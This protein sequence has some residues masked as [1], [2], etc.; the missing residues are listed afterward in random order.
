MFKNNKS[1]TFQS[2]LYTIITFAFSWVFFIPVLLHSDYK[3]V[4]DDGIVYL[5]IGSFGPTVGAIVTYLLFN[6]KAATQ[7]WLKKCFNFKFGWSQYFMITLIPGLI[8]FILFSLFAGQNAQWYTIFLTMAPFMIFSWVPTFIAGALGEEL[9]W[10]GF[11]T[12]IL[13]NKYNNVVVALVVGTIWAL[14][15]LPLLLISSYRSELGFGVYFILYIIGTTAQ[16]FAFIKLSSITKGSVIAAI[17][18]H[19]VFNKTAANIFENSLFK[20]DLTNPGLLNVLMLTPI[21]PIITTVIFSVI[22]DKKIIKP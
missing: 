11:L 17:L 1:P 12:H 16:S 20:F 3:T 18:L 9:G 22:I 4:P 21:L 6:G 14:W 10:R 5:I 13:Q 19:A 2:I 15:H 7:M 8:G